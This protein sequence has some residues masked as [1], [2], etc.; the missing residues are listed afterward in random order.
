[1]NDHKTRRGYGEL[2]FD[3]IVFNDGA[4]ELD[5]SEE[6]TI[7]FRLKAISDV[8]PGAFLYLGIRDPMTSFNITDSGY[9]E[10]FRDKLS[11]GSSV[12][13]LFKI[14]PNTFRTGVFPLLFWIG[15]NP[16]EEDYH[17]DVLDGLYNLTLVSS[18]P[19]LELGYNS[20]NPNGLFSLDF[21]L[22]KIN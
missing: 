16:K 11:A 2:R 9:V 6:I 4:S 22:I 14:A 5:P 17:Y 13:F 8:E 3:D 15:K 21:S 1:L 18:K 7:R 12:S 19:T 10:L 20:A